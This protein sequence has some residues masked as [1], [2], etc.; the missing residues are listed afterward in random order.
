MMVY[1]IAKGVNQGYLNDSRMEI[2]ERGYEGIL[3]EFIEVDENG[4]VH[5]HDVC[6]VA[7]LGGSPYRDGSYEYYISEPIRTNDTKATGPFIRASLQLN[8]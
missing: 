7:G 6:S 8:R 3:N 5:I 4:H 1:A 2:A